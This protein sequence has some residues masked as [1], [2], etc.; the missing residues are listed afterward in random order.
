MYYTAVCTREFKKYVFT[1]DAGL[2]TAGEETNSQRA[3]AG[4]DN[5]ICQA[6]YMTASILLYILQ[7]IMSISINRLLMM[8]VYRVYHTPRQRL[9]GTPRPKAR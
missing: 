5:F 3:A 2:H 6:L 8:Y 1:R 7:R 4:C 9:F